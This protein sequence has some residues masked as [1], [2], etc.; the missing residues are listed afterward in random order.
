MSDTDKTKPLWVKLRQN[1]K[2]RVELHYHEKNT[3]DLLPFEES[4]DVLYSYWSRR[5]GISCGYWVSKE[6]H[7]HVWGRC[8]NAEQSYRAEA[9]GKA[10]RQ[11][12]HLRREVIKMTRED[13]YDCE[14]LSHPHR[15]SALWDVS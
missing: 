2:W 7:Q 11:V 6:G 1:P 4:S 15:R 13:I 9:N 8:S 10:R 14:F 5:K 3:C 12:R